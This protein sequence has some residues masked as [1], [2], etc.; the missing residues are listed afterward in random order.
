MTVFAQRLTRFVR[1][2]A[3]ALGGVAA[4][5]GTGASAQ[6]LPPAGT[7]ISNQATAT[8]QLGDVTVNLLSNR[9]QLTVSPVEGLRLT[10]DND[11][12]APAGAPVNLPH[13]LTNTGNVAATYAFTATNLT[14]DDYDLRDLRIYGDLNA[15][16]IVDDGEPRLDNASAP[17]ALQPGQSTDLLVSGFVPL[18]AQ[19]GQS[20]RVRLDAAT[21][22]GTS[23]GTVRAANTDTIRVAAGAAVEVR[24]EASTQ[25]GARGQIVSYDLVATSRGSVAPQ[26]AIITVDGAQRQL[27]LLRDTIPTNTSFVSWATNNAANPLLYHRVGAAENVYTSTPQSVVDSVAL[28]LTGF[29]PGTTAR[30]T[31]R[32]RINDNASGNFNNTADVIYRDGTTEARVIA[33]SNT[34]QI[35]VPLA[36][37][38]LT[39]Y[40]DATYVR[41]ANVTGA[42]RPLFLQ[43]DSSA[44]NQDS[45][46]AERVTLD[47]R[48]S[49]TGDTISTEMLETGPN[50]GVFRVVNPVATN[51]GD[52]VADDGVLQIRSD[53]VLVARLGG[54]GTV[55]ALARI[56]VDPL[57]IVYDARTNLPLSGARVTLVDAATGQP[58]RV[59]DFDGITPRPSTVITGA[60]G[61]FQFPQVAPGTYR[62]QIAPPANYVFPSKLAPA[63]QPPGR[64]ID[65]SGSYGGSFAVN[66]QTGTVS[67]DVPLD[68]PPGAGLFI[69]K[70]ARVR[71]AEIGGTVDYQVTVRNVAP[72]AVNGLQISDS[73]PRGFTFVPR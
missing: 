56:L 3:F 71:D 28:G 31:L 6:T 61:A 53:D 16:G 36:P 45:T 5:A 11:R 72:I 69:D 24:K 15:N 14:G 51:Q 48:S 41:Q 4:L 32:V 50:T 68:P 66:A 55:D 63:N 64:T 20:A 49:L 21:A 9:V 34:V 54:C 8:Y 40:T 47:L 23:T 26:P 27:A 57:G 35:A 1:P 70:I 44:C 30:A 58:A 7:P 43:G 12:L 33:P 42:N 38:T 52:A 39:Y 67:L 59:F 22:T 19:S 25:N 65:A 62:L 18:T 13:R 73:L 29:G 46:V 10:A 37:P 17:I 2:I 60:D